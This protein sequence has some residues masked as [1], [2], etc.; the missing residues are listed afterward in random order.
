MADYSGA[1]SLSCCA[2]STLSGH[3]FLC[4]SN[5]R[6]ETNRWMTDHEFREVPIPGAGRDACFWGCVVCGV[7]CSN[8]RLH[9]ELCIRGEYVLPPEDDDVVEE[10]HDGKTLDRT[11]SAN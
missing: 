5:P 6:Y 3:L 11:D 1:Y 4:E 7:L 2:G 10:T 8:A 9:R